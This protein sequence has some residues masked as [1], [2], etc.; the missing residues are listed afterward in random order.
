M[1]QVALRLAELDPANAAT[2]QARTADFLA[3][4]KAA[5]QQVAATPF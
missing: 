5:L 4:W 1:R 3:R 2:Y